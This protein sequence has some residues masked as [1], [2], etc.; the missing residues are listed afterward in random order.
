MSY[1]DD[2]YNESQPQQPEH[3]FNGNEQGQQHKTVQAFSVIHDVL[4]SLGFPSGIPYDVDARPF[5]RT[6]SGAS[7]P[8]RRQMGLNY[9]TGIRRESKVKDSSRTICPGSAE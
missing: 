7:A 4:L 2:Y 3:Q 6:A 9:Y 8:G 5:C 1:F